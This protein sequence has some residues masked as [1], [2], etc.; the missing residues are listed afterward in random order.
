MLY[1]PRCR[2]LNGALPQALWRDTDDAEASRARQQSLAALVGKV[3]E[4]AKQAIRAAFAA[5]G[6]D[7]GAAAARAAAAVR[8]LES[9]NHPMFVRCRPRSFLP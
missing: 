1:R 2:G 3:L 5:A 7:A 4:Q 6:A 9:L 8:V